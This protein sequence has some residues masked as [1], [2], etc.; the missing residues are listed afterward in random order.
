M[1]NNECISAHLSGVN[2][3]LANFKLNLIEEE[4]SEYDNFYNRI[5]I[6][7]SNMVSEMKLVYFSV[8]KQFLEKEAKLNDTIRVLLLIK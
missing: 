2:E 3:K 8:S 7:F 4:E 1:A 6:Y 5:N